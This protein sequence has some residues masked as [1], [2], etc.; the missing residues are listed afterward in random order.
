MIA[1]S[2]LLSLQDVAEKL[3]LSDKT[4]RK[5]CATGELPAVKLASRW[6]VRRCDFESVLNPFSPAPVR[7]R[8]ESSDDSA[9]AGEVDPPSRQSPA[10]SRG[11]S[12]QPRRE[13]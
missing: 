12:R 3:R 4:V 7:G 1:T 2:E 6:Y 13:L 11:F 8:V 10:G 5:L 9:V